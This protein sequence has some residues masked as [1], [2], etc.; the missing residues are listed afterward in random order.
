MGSD[1][2]EGERVN[3]SKN[4][5]EEDTDAWSGSGVWRARESQ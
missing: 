1:R 4:G 3:E 2:R 5:V